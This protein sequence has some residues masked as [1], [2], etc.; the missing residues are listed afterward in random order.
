MSRDR[1]E[2]TNNTADLNDDLGGHQRST[3]SRNVKVTLVDLL[4]R[5]TSDL[6]IARVEDKTGRKVGS[7]RIGASVR[8]AKEHRTVGLD[9][10]VLVVVGDLSG[11]AEL[12]LRDVEEVGGRDAHEGDVG[13][14]S[15]LKLKTKLGC[16]GEELHVDGVITRSIIDLG[17]SGCVHSTSASPATKNQSIVNVDTSAITILAMR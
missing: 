5:G 2:G 13:G 3:G 9:G 6:T 10:N 15:P 11:V 4:S 7:D 17:V 16:A 1:K 8:R 12:G 14:S